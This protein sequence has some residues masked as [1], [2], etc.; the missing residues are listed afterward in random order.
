MNLTT[1]VN[2]LLRQA[3][4]HAC[5]GS[6][7]NSKYTYKLESYKYKDYEIDF[8]VDFEVIM[9]DIS[10]PGSEPEWKCENVY[11]IYVEAKLFENQT[12]ISCEFEYDKDVYEELLRNRLN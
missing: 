4:N 11:M 12:Q 9:N 7:E 6:I 2:K 1:I 8:E 5:L 10:T 3:V